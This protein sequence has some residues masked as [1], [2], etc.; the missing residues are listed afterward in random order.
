MKKPK[1]AV[2][3]AF[4]QSASHVLGELKLQPY[5]PSRIVAADAMGLK[6][7]NIPKGFEQYSQTGTY[8]GILRDIIVVLGVCRMEDEAV[9]KA[10]LDPDEAYKRAEKWAHGKGITD[11][12]G[13]AFREAKDVF[14]AILVQV[15]TSRSE[16]AKSSE[17]DDES[18]ND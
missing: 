7:P 3:Q 5:T 9:D 18:G 12:R 2:E 17:P 4:E 11:M 14:E 10:Q 13:K 6:Y 16:S 1:P 8:T 15:A